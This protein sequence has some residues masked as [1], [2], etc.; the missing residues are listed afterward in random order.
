MKKWKFEKEITESTKTLLT[1]YLA[2]MHSTVITAVYTYNDIVYAYDLNENDL[3]TLATL[4]AEKMQINALGKKRI[5]KILEKSE[6]VTT[7]EKITE[8]S[9][10]FEK[11]NNGYITEF[12][13]RIIKNNETISDIKHSNNSKGFDV[14][15]DTKD[16]RQ[17]KNL[18]NKAT[19][20]TYDYL[21]K[22]CKRK[23]YK[24][25]DKVEKAIET[26]REIYK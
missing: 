9:K 16:N 11:Y 4:T 17:I 13:Y 12:A 3:E 23:G 7:T 5:E 25:I 21:I 18:D 10:H 20:T 2:T 22:A 15:S 24:D 1:A 6:K 14:A 19:F 8:I 26:I